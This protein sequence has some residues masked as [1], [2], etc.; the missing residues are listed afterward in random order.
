MGSGRVRWLKGYLVSLPIAIHLCKMTKYSMQHI[1]LYGPPG[2]GKTYQSRKLSKEKD[3]PLWEADDLR[4]T[5]RSEHTR[6]EDPFVYLGTTEAYKE[7]GELNRENVIKGLLAVRSAMWPFIE[8]RAKGFESLIIEAAFI[9][10]FK[11]REYGDVR[12]VVEMDDKKYEGQF[13]KN[14]ERTK[15][16]LDSFIAAKWIR[17]YMVGEKTNL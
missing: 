15:E 7:F 12:L 4:A 13:F 9:D 5:A 11:A 1:F 3:I 17:D 6:E 2:S 14:R 10:P 16:T 8:R